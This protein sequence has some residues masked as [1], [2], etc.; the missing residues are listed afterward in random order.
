MRTITQA[1]TVLTVTRKTALSGLLGAV[2]I[3]LGVT[4][5]GF[6]PFP[7][8]PGVDAT[9]MHV[10]AIIGGVLGGPLVGL[11]IGA[12]FGSYSW[13]YAATPL[14][15]DPLVA[16]VPRLLIGV[17]AALVYR[18]LRPVSPAFALGTAGLVGTLT[19]TVGVLGV[20][21]WR[22]YLAPDVAL[23][24]GITHGIPE[25]VVAVLITVP[26]GLAID[27]GARRLKS[28]V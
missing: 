3:L 12:I 14:F 22:G 25:I 5:L 6:I 8:T 28:T 24:V 7:L 10:P 9:I 18:G 20:A 27:A 15:K 13:L 1:D 16:I 4:R 21:V 23:T 26:V 2:A 19:N 11:A 17:T